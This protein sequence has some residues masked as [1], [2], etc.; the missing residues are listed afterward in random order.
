MGIAILLGL[1]A[2]LQMMSEFDNEKKPWNREIYYYHTFLLTLNFAQ[3]SLVIFLRCVEKF[4]WLGNELMLEKF[5]SVVVLTYN[6]ENLVVKTLNIIYNQT[7]YNQTI[8]NIELVICED[9]SKDNTQKVI[10]DWV[11]SPKEVHLLNKRWVFPWKVDL[12]SITDVIDK[13]TWR[14]MKG[15]EEIGK[16]LDENLKYVKREVSG[17]K[18]T[19]RNK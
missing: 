15:I 17:D 7:I 2:S 19:I 11:E 10:V 4:Y 5:F 9:A 8:K 14:K 12:V 18:I 6:Q 1:S 16:L 3:D 13:I